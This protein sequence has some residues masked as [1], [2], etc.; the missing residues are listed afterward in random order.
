MHHENETSSAAAPI[1]S[2]SA[3]RNLLKGRVMCKYCCPSV[4]TKGSRVAK[5]GEVVSANSSRHPK[6][7]VFVSGSHGIV[8]IGAMV[9][10][11]TL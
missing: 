6:H 1:V 9:P 4:R 11:E 5:Q 7:S 2:V 10:S 3:A 8:G